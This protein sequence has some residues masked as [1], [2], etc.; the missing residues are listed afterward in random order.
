MRTFF[1][2]IDDCQNNTE[3]IVK[4]EATNVEEARVKAL[5]ALHIAESL[6]SIDKEEAVALAEELGLPIIGEDGCETD[7]NDEEDN[8]DD[9]KTIK[10]NACDC[11]ALTEYEGGEPVRYTKSDKE[12]QEWLD[13]N[14]EHSWFPVDNNPGDEEE[15]I[16]QR[17]LKLN[18]WEVINWIGEHDMLY[19]DFCSY[20]HYKD[21]DKEPEIDKIV[22]WLS[23]HDQ[24]WEDFV[25]AFGLDD[26]ED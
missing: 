3:A 16:Y 2:Q 18:S 24:A 19:E 6:Y 20:F 14:E 25:A 26:E 11:I 13:A 8:N 1:I 15:N 22:D 17:A 12:L 23:E 7:V 10:E 21:G 9:N 5:K 4:V